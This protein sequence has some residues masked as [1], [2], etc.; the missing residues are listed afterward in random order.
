MQ[1][2]MPVIHFFQHN[3]DKTLL[4]Y[5]TNGNF[6]KIEI[7]FFRIFG[8]K[9][10]KYDRC[11]EEKG[12]FWTVKSQNNDNFKYQKYKEKL[13]H[14]RRFRNEELCVAIKFSNII[15]I[16]IFTRTVYIKFIKTECFKIE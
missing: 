15:S 10:T 5:K 3:G 12:V 13:Y 1:G 14:C 7:L 8:T 11:S 4:F 9:K 6:M 2:K 16:I